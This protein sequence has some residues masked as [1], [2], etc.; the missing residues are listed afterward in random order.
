MHPVESA[1]TRRAPTR[2]RTNRSRPPHFRMTFIRSQFAP[3][4]RHYQSYCGLSG[5]LPMSPLPV[6]ATPTMS[7][8]RWGPGWSRQLCVFTSDY[9]H[10]ENA[11]FGRTSRGGQDGLLVC[12]GRRSL[13]CLPLMVLGEQLSPV[14]TKVEAAPEVGVG[15]IA[16]RTGPERSPS[17]RDR[18]EA[19]TW[20]KVQR[21]T[22]I[23]QLPNERARRANSIAGT[24]A[25][26]RTRPWDLERA[27]GRTNPR[28]ANSASGRLIA[29]NDP[30]NFQ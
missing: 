22:L 29:L 10:S 8:F 30:M 17:R 20:R 27:N 24:T 1:L 4:L 21:D 19:A 12:R 6:G 3:R 5:T 23:P 28:G 2:Q 9:T 25:L 18:R 11:F 14:G 16:H 26:H 13:L 15:P 7:T